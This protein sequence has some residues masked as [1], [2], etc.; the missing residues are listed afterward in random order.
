MDCD[1]WCRY[2]RS[3]PGRIPSILGAGAASRSS[4]T[5]STISLA[6]M[7]YR[8]SPRLADLGEARFWR[9]DKSADYGPLNGIARHRVNVERIRHHWED[10][11]RLAGSLQMGTVPAS[12]V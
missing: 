2:G 12:D 1:L 9:M 3:M 8:F 11:L 7:G 5:R 10:L 6:L 4:T